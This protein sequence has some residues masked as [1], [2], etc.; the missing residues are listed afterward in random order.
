MLQDTKIL[1]DHSNISHGL[2]STVGC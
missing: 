1:S 2:A